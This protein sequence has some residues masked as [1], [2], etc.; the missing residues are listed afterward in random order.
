MLSVLSSYA[1]V[2]VNVTSISKTGYDLTV[3]SSFSMTLLGTNVIHVC[4]QKKILVQLLPTLEL[5]NLYTSPNTIRVIKSGMR[6]VG[7]E[8]HM[9]AE[10]YIQYFS[11]RS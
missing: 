7:H 8:A 9:R 4:T 3:I 5:H 10:K 1:K 2:E 11:W 6:L